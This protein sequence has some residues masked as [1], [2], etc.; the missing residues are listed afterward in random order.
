MNPK[1]V[2]APAVKSFSES[3]VRHPIQLAS[4][5]LWA[6]R[7]NRETEIEAVAAARLPCHVMWAARDTILSR[8]DGKEFARRLHATFTVAEPP[9][10][11]GPIDHDWMFDDSELFVQHLDKLGLRALSG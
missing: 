1:K 3:W 7:S 9:P 6:F 8:K 11:Y 10:G 5:A 2:T 4:A